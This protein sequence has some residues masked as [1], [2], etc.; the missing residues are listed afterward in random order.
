MS[1]LRGVDIFLEA[2]IAWEGCHP[3]AVESKLSWFL[4]NLD[5][6]ELSFQPKIGT[7][8][9]V[10]SFDLLCQALHEQGSHAEG[11]VRIVAD[12]DQLTIIFQG[13]KT[14]DVLTVI[15]SFEDARRFIKQVRF[16]LELLLGLTG[17][18]DD[19]WLHF[20]QP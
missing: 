16:L 15:F 13:P 14:R 18:I 17:D 3:T 19:E 8:S 10:F 6:V 7:P 2:K 12:D 5:E 9:Q 11:R 4:S 20:N 1:T